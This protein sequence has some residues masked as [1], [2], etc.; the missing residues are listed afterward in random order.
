MPAI[1][2]STMQRN[3]LRQLFERH[4][5]TPEEVA[6]LDYRCVERLPKVGKK[7]I[8]AIRVWLAQYGYDLRNVPEQNGEQ[9][10]QRLRLRLDQ[11]VRLLVK[12]GYR[13]EPPLSNQP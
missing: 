7:G 4:E 6:Q 5:F 9:L 2:L 10:E 13:V 1:D 3:A 8:G 12:H 11:A